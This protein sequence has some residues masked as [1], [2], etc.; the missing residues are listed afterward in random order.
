MKK[1]MILMG[2]LLLSACGKESTTDLLSIKFGKNSVLELVKGEK[3]AIYSNYV[4]TS[5]K[6]L[7]MFNGLDLTGYNSNKGMKNSLV[8]YYKKEDKTIFYY[9]VQL[10]DASIYKKL[11]K[12]LRKRFGKADY[13]DYR[14]NASG[15]ID[16]KHDKPY[17]YI[18]EDKIGKR[19]FI[20]VMY[21]TDNIHLNV[22]VNP[23]T[24]KEIPGM[25]HAGCWND[26]LYVRNK[27]KDGSYTYKQ[28][29]EDEKSK[30]SPAR[31]ITH[32]KGKE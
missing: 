23:L 8:L 16:F 17:S 3:C 31:C 11:L 24:S 29:L 21:G 32:T 22:M 7:M 27:K 6:K 18:W 4:S 1:I 14:S 15:S 5:S 13:R 26:F 2:I 19:L 25:A 30:I 20:V 9:S 10:L 28:Y 12:V